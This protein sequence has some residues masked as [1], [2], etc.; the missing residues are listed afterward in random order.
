MSWID[1]LERKFGRYAIR[2]LMKYIVILN[3]T[4]FF[5]GMFPDSEAFINKLV[6]DPA[7]VAR[8]EVW[9]LF[10]YIFIPQ[11]RSPIWIIFVLYFSYMI[12]TNLENIWGSFRF[13][14]YYLIGMLGTTIA[15]YIT[16]G[17][18]T[19]IYLNLSLF[20]AFAYMFPD[21]EI[22]IYFILPVKVK[23]LGWI[24][25]A[26]IGYTVLF[27]PFLSNKVVAVASVLN[28]I[29][30]FGPGIIRGTN[31]RRQS[32]NRRQDFKKKKVAAGPG[33][34]QKCEVCGITHN[35]DPKMEFR[36]CSKCDGRHCYCMNH[37]REHE[38]VKANP[39]DKII[40]FPGN[41]EDRQE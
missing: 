13:N 1:K 37:I 21:Y 26:F 39:E 36:Y 38:H 5:I 41:K 9:R 33:L 19:A 3:A 6:L 24:S 17:P 11:D 22:M 40:S 14:L 34:L 15:V 12:G 16:G 8:G 2:G 23:Y 4:V 18:G 31:T 7:G 20:L 35:D 29:V 27:N 32:Y 25:W 30:F 10:T 28:F